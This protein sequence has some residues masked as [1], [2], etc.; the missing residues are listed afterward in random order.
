M[1]RR[2]PSFWSRAVRE[3]ARTAEELI[4]LG[5]SN[6]ILAVNGVFHTASG[7]DAVAVAIECD[8]RAIL[9]DL[10]PA[11]SALPRVEVPLRPYDMVGLAPMRTLL[12][13]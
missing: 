10:P 9:S 8:Q 7:T 13:P 4:D 12:A 5:L 3:A 11:L 1:L 6:K 2:R